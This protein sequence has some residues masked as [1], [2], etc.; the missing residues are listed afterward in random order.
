VEDGRYYSENNENYDQATQYLVCPRTADEHQEAIE[1]Q[2]Y[3][4][5]VDDAREIKPG[6]RR[7]NG[8]K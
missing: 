6:E 8:L 2:S 3:D 1:D 7:N 5:D 4:K